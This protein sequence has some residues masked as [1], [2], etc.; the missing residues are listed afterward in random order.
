MRIIPNK[1]W[2]KTSGFSNRCVR[3]TPASPGNL[4]EAG[5]ASFLFLSQQLPLRPASQLVLNHGLHLLGYSTPYA[6]ASLTGGSSSSSAML[7]SGITSFQL[8]NQTPLLTSNSSPPL[9]SGRLTFYYAC[10]FE[11]MAIIG[12]RFLFHRLHWASHACATFRVASVRRYFPGA[13]TSGWKHLH[14]R[15]RA[16][17][18]CRKRAL[19]AAC[20]LVIIWIFPALIYSPNV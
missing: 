2:I 3:L 15:R 10:A 11:Q 16:A 14:G 18:R 17:S 19:G 7:A 5:G 1:P 12:L 9:Q 4:G 6:S 13:F 20:P 8:Q